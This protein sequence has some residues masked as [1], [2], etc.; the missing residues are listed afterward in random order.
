M[1]LPIILLLLTGCSALFAQNN[2]ATFTESV[3]FATASPQLDQEAKAKIAAFTAQLNGYAEFSIQLEAFTDEQGKNEYN[4]KLAAS[5]A[6]SVK[7]YLETS[8]VSTE[9]WS[10]AA[11]GE[12]LAKTNTTDDAQRRTDRRVD[13]IA[14]VTTW[15]NMTDVLS[16]LR[17]NLP[18]QIIIDPT[19]METIRG[20]K[21]G[22]FLITP[23]SF[24]DVDGKPVEGPVT[25]EL[26]EAYSLDD[27]M[28]AGLTTT[29]GDRTLETGGMF[30]LTATDEAGNPLQ[31][32]E[33]KSIASAI[34]TDNFNPEMQIFNGQHGEDSEQLDWSLTPMGVSPSPSTLQWMKYD[35][36]VLARWEFDLGVAIMAWKKSNP[37]PQLALRPVSSNRKQP[38][39]PDTNAIRWEPSLVDGIFASKE[40]RARMRRQLVAKAWDR[41]EHQQEVY[42]KR[43]RVSE[44]NSAY[45]AQARADFPAI[46]EAWEQ[47]LE[48]EKERLRSENV[49]KNEALRAD[50]EKRRD[51][52]LAKRKATLETALSGDDLAGKGEELSDYF[53]MINR[54]GWINCDVFYGE[55]DPIMVKAAID[56][57]NEGAKVIL[58]PEGRRAM[59][60]YFPQLG[61]YWGANG[62]P[63]NTS[64]KV[65]A[66][67]ISEGQLQYA[68]QEIAAASTEVEIL[69]FR[70]VSL[71][72]LKER[73]AGLSNAK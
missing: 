7:T 3:Y 58:I 15:D 73:L 49:A 63:R 66:Y 12:R 45:N 9:S 30:K 13:L 55:E 10:I 20:E 42:A 70:P 33:G 60:P 16:Q 59:L 44:E 71:E 35:G 67:Q 1:R 36:P 2:V 39:E 50:Y 25:V 41:Y 69:A 56:Q 65:V 6:S 18:Q 34:P 40:K 26:V 57:Y 31:L 48:A 38:E 43:V 23:N 64:Y 14:T 4:D 53:F 19:Q 17:S 32:A 72:E 54:L 8:G 24:I 52:W 28:L 61:G 11:H 51:A 46:K 22:R 27:M 47:A 5:R 68:E 62:I 37:E 29:S 21:G